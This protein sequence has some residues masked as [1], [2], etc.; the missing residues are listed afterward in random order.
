[1]KS[2]RILL[3]VLPLN[4]LFASAGCG[5]DEPPF[6]P[7]NDLCD[8]YSEEVCDGREAC[9]EAFDRASCE[10]SVRSGCVADV[11][12]LTNQEGL[13]YDGQEANR[14][15]GQLQE[16]LDL[17]LAPVPLGRFFVGTVANGAACEQPAQC[18][19]VTCAPDAAGTAMVCSDP[20]GKALCEAADI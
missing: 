14:V 8:V 2:R 10:T 6:L 19:S 4:V 17:C 11:D 1:M 20:A 9:C 13:A 12:L 7:L 15:R 18:Q 3:L 16:A 5:D